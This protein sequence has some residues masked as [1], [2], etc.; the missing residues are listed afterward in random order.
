MIL[1]DTH[2]LVWLDTGSKRLGTKCRERIEEAYR[3]GEV[4]VSAISFWEVAMQESRGRI[5]LSMPTGSWRRDLLA[6]GVREIPVD[7]EVGIAAAT[8]EDFHGDPADRILAATAILHQ[9][10]L[11]TADRKILAWPGALDRFD[12][13]R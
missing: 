4:A 1:L 8:I 10:E 13:T 2:V 11:V 9:T 7:G 12:A 5:A 6:S 3:E